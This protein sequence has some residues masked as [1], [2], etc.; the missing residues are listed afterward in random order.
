M[1]S[2]P[3]L[4]ALS[5]GLGLLPAAAGA[6]GGDLPFDIAI[7][8]GLD[9]VTAR[10]VTIEAPVGVPVRMGALEI[11]ARA[12]KKRRPED[13]PESAAFLDIWELRP[14]LPATGL[15]RGWMFASSP[16]LSAMEHPVYDIWVL[17]CRNAKGR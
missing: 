12:C 9:K 3:I 17:D 8:Q 16:A 6:Q 4:A 13:Q 5:L 11:V 15:F 7:L 10:V 2:G 1:R 14:D